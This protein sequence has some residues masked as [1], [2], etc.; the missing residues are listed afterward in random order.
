MSGDAPIAFRRMIGVQ[1]HTDAAG[2][3][4][5]QDGRGRSRLVAEQHRHRACGDPGLGH[6]SRDTARFAR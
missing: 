3:Q 4:Y 6:G 2:G 5:A 1:R